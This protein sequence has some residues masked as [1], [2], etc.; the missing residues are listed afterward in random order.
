MTE[1]KKIL[2]IGGGSGQFAL[3][4]GL[5]ELNHIDI[6]SVV[7][8]FDSGGSTGRLRRQLGML[9]PGDAVKCVLALSPFGDIAEK[10][11]LKKFRGH[12]GLQGHHAGNLLLTALSQYTGSFPVAIQ[13]LAEVLEARGRVLP[14]T[15]D[16]ATLVAELS[17]GK[18]IFGESAIDR[19]NGE[20]RPKIKNLLLV[21]HHGDR[22]SVYPPVLDAISATDH[23][24]IGPGDLFTSIL[25]CLILPGI[26][27]ALQRTAAKILYVMNIMTKFGETDGFNGFDFIQKLEECVER[28]MD[29]IIYNTKK[30]G[31][32]TLKL[33]AD[34]K[35]EFVEFEYDQT[36]GEKRVIHACDLLAEATSM[37]RHDSAKLAALIKAIVF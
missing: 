3:L 13:A 30:P 20:Q 36:L 31:Q 25:S 28:R 27:E 5:R 12:T 24:I 7:S 26:K 6:T 11:L 18:R 34:Q 4:A 23:I 17:D 33:Y 9:P 1:R 32:E 14:V 19:P 15:I 37:V 16:K 35:A 8:M 10:M 22:V 29:G 21:P 2:T